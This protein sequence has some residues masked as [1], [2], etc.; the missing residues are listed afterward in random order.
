MPTTTPAS[1]MT[2]W[3]EIPRAI[4]RGAPI[5]GGGT[6]GG[7][8]EYGCTRRLRP[9]TRHDGAQT[10]P[11][12]DPDRRTVRIGPV[13]WTGDHTYISSRTAFHDNASGGTAA[14]GQEPQAPGQ[15]DRP[16]GHREHCRR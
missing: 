13:R 8:S 5:I 2:V 10:F 16:R 12:A 6:G 14:G 3:P 1:S 11:N 9:E 4:F 7:G 15:D